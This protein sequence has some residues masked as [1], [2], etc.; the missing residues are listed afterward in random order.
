MNKKGA[1]TDLIVLC[2]VAFVLVVVSG[3]MYYAV[4]TTKAQLLAIAPTISAQT[5][6]NMTLIVENSLNPV[7]G[8]YDNLPWICVMIIVGNILSIIIFS[9]L[10]R[11]NAAWFWAY[12]LIVAISAI[13]AVSISNAYEVIANYPDFSSTFDHFTVANALVLNLP[14]IVM[15][16]GLIGATILFIN[17][18]WSEQYA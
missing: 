12:V 9:A 5:G 17:I 16:T 15:V 13:I 14:I 3:L 1:L 6:T 8:S 4:V 18:R 7:I 10:V 2:I 11:T